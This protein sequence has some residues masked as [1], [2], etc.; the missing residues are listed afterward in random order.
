MSM[1]NENTKNEKKVWKTQGTRLLII[2]IIFFV[3]MTLGILVLPV[4]SIVVAAVTITVA[5]TVSLVYIYFF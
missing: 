5:F 1:E 2:N 4:S 3:I